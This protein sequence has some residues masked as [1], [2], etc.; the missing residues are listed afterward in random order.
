M[1]EDVHALTHIGMHGACVG[2][3][4]CLYAAE[5]GVERLIS[6]YPSLLLNCFRQVLS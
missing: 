2:C 3:I 1:C 5:S 4:L 6:G